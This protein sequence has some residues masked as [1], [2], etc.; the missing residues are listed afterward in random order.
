[1]ERSS[2]LVVNEGPDGSGK[3]TQTTL[4]CER[5]QRE[6]WRVARFDFPTYGQDPVADLIRTM[7]K[8]MPEEW[9]SRPWES[10]AVLFA[11]NRRR[12]R[13]PIME[14]LVSP[15]TVVVCNRYVPSNAAH[16]AGYV[17]DPAEWERRFQWVEHLEYELMGLPH[18]DIAFLHTMPQHA[19]DQLLHARERGAKDAHEADS[20]YLSRVARC[21]H[22][23]ARR[24]SKQ[25]IHVPADIGGRV[26]PPQEIHERLWQAF[27]QHAAWRS[28][29]EQR[30]AVRTATHNPG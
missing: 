11:S 12:F 5:L 28:F 16:M 26:E 13:E 20:A 9:N 14:A 21:F 29:V 1:M 24:D 8:S 27:T 2:L 23:L 4:L 19:A 6:G 3:G 7:L 10:K 25:W 15:G 22:A 30:A 17:D 18:P